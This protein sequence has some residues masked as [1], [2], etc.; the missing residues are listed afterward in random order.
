MNRSP[1]NPLRANSIAIIGMAGRFPGAGT[2]GQFWSNL[3]EG[4][5]SITF[6]SDEE[7]L[8]AGADPELLERPDFVKASPILEDIDQFDAGF[9]K[10]G[11]REAELMDPQQRILLELGS[12]TLER[13]GYAGESRRGLVGV[14]SG[15]GGLM[16]SYLLSPLH[17]R[18]RLVGP[19]GSM[20]C[21]GND[22]DYLSTRLSYKL[23]LR[24]P[25]FTV[26]TACSTSLVAVHLACQS[27]LA[28]E[29][30]M[31]LAGGVT[32]RVPHRM[33]YVHSGQALLSPDGHCRPFDADAEGTLFG[34]GAGL[35]LLKPLVQ[36]VADRDHIHAVIR[37]SAINNDGA[38]KLSYWAASADGQAAAIADALAV[39]EVEPE[40]IGYMEAHG[41]ATT[42]GDP[43]EIFALTKAFRRGTQ[44]RQFCPLGS[45]KGN[46]GHLEAAAGVCS[47]IKAVLAL[48]HNTVP[49]SLHFSRPNPAID[50]TNTPFFV[51]TERRAWQPGSTPRRAAVNS[52]GIGGTNAHLIL[53][54]APELPPPEPGPER[55]VHLLTLSAK[56]PQALRELADRY[57]DCFNDR[58]ELNLADVCFTANAGRGHFKHRLAISAC[59]GDEARRRLIA[60]RQKPSRADCAQGTVD[61]PNAD[62][63]F[64]FAGQDAAYAGMA[65]QLYETEPIFR[66][67]L[68]RCDGILGGSLGRP[69]L[70]IL[71]PQTEGGKS[72]ERTVFVQPALFAVEYALAQLWKSWGVEPSAVIGH[73][74][75]EYVA[76]CVAGVFTLEEGLRLVAARAR[77][78]EALPADDR[79]L[80]VMVA[81][82]QAASL[83]APYA[84]EVTLV[85]VNSP[86]QIVVSGRAASIDLL[87]AQLQ[88]EGIRSRRLPVFHAF[89]SPRMEAILDDFGQVCADVAFRKPRTR[90]IGGLDGKPIGDEI[91]SADYWLRHLCE[92]VQFAAGVMALE[93]QGY[94]NFL[95]ISPRPRL[96]GLG[97]R[98]MKQWAGLWLPS[99]RP[100]RPDW[101][102]LLS[103]LARLYVHGA[104]IDWD[105][106][107]RNFSRRRVVLPT[108]PFQRRRY[109][110]ADDPLDDRH[111]SAFALRSIKEAD[112]R[113]LAEELAR[114]GDFSDEEVALLPRML[115]GLAQRGR[116]ESAG[117]PVRE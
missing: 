101:D 22:K 41:T 57:A 59:S 78:A 48:E 65:R 9:F 45:V 72:L 50:F 91:A 31:A 28:G 13:A 17:V 112:L 51:N 111:D 40:T 87:A 66:K 29:C 6:F 62:V 49:P 84:G 43:V 73:G 107:D 53:E 39:A 98:C 26:Q 67:T 77:L 27:L 25:S 114:T 32:V 75:G 74:V 1:Q 102:T 109:W 69:L 81:P 71:Y 79:M 19:T 11:R 58:P 100:G 93:E 105:G 54:E 3:V 34:S 108:Y 30:D 60:W 7:L 117:S 97:R 70:A 106:F 38:A 14:F 44:E 88:R 103:S 16:S 82:S 21:V 63:A 10:V 86:R 110:A 33:G 23:N 36:A 113:K 8:A 104:K 99:L 83:L 47:L 116:Q 12:E 46:V 96:L 18:R 89:H 55:P 2:I 61:S 24:G 42:M 76:A 35:V 95:E 15:A 92:P 85:A 90:L 20:Q 4:V 80:A 52:L 56:T 64:L 37:G 115:R 94:K 68:D 5:D